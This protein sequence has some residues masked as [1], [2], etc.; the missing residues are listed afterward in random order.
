MNDND[1]SRRDALKAIGAAG[2]LGVAGCSGDGDGNGD[3]GNGDSPTPTE[4][5][6]TET[7][8]ATES[9]GE[10][11]ETVR[12]AFLYESP[13]GDVGW[14]RSHENG[15]QALE[16]E[17]DWIETAYTDGVAPGDSQSVIENYVSEGYDVIFGT[18]FGYMDP[19][20]QLAPEYPDTIFEHCSGYRTDENLGRYFGRLYQPRYLTGVAAGHLTE[21]NTL[22]YVASFPISEVIRQLNA[23]ALGAASV[24]PD[25][26]MQ[27]R[28]TNAWLDPPA[29]TEATNAL[30]DAG[31]DVIN[32]HVTSPAAVR[33]ADEN[34]AWG[35]TY[36]TSMSEQGGEM[37]GGSAIW[38]WEEFYGPALESVRDG[39]WESDFYWEG[40]ES[41]VVALDEFGPNVPDEVVSDVE[42]K[43]QQIV[44]GELD[45][46]ADS[47][48]EGWSDQELFQNVA[49]FAEPVEGEPPS[50]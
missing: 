25:V 7:A 16:E 47:Q 13:L 14:D 34:D 15:R 5:P 37:Y 35:F 3:G 9:G 20:A 2:I 29:T 27:V 23:F 44:D 24:N 33:T 11:M 38:E 6:G 17:Y 10:E 21:T 32:N 48:F 4:S 46:W 28:W 40:L 50:S 49:S 39:S 43:R 45:V 26:T 31:A 42:D 8:T 22:G 36:T 12:A 41:G 30:L 18:S 19:M 1:R